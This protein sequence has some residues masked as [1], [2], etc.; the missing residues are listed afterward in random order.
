MLEDLKKS[1]CDANLELVR[2]GMVIYTWGNVSGI[3]DDRRY[4]VIK[5]S[6]VDYDGMT[7]EDMVVV[8]VKTGLKVEGNGIL[9]RTQKLIWNF[10][11]QLMR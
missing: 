1:V 5:P 11:R 6:G 7:P 9:L 2:R 8:D 4:M 10:I 3:S